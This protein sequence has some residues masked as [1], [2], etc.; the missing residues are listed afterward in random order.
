M[1]LPVVYLA[2]RPRAQSKSEF[3]L[4]TAL[5]YISGLYRILSIK[6]FQKKIFVDQMLKTLLEKKIQTGHN[7]SGKITLADQYCFLF[8]SPLPQYF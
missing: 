2:N 3:M 7:H 5:V 1:N 6:D 8:Q 4:D